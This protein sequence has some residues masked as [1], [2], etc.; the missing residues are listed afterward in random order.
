MS[1][2]TIGQAIPQAEALR[3]CAEIRAA[4]RHKRLSLASAQCWG[5]IKFSRGDPAK[6][7][8]SSK[9]GNRGCSLVNARYG[10]R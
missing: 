7:C 6:M 2:D 9:P 4:N 3:L 1:A 8:L 5:C 10:R